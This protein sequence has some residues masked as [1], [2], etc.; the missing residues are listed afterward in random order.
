MFSDEMSEIAVIAVA[1]FVGS[2]LGVLIDRLPRS[3]SVIAPA[4]SCRR[5]GH[6]LGPFDLIP[7]MSW[8]LAA[9]RCRYCR[10]A[11]GSL[12][13]AIELAALCI[14]IWSVAVAPG[15]VAVAGAVLGWILLPL[16][17]IDYREL[18]LPDGLTLAMAGAGLAV[19]ALLRAEAIADHVVGAA[20]G[21]AVLAAVG[22]VYRRLRGR[23]GLGLGD[24]KLLG[25]AGAWLGWQGLP[26]VVFLAAAAAMAIEVLKRR[27]LGKDAALLPVPFGTY[28]A[29]AT[30]L[31]WLY[32]PI[33]VG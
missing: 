8:A 30:W 26:S 11:I 25:A 13:P 20:A 14:A 27:P 32:G 22:E 21:F 12:A 7:I 6:A 3:E 29:G 9:G 5:C 1:P 23:D 15:P 18:W 16:A 10:G 28:L 31:V 19:A 24:A 2:F 4:S 17:V 33:A